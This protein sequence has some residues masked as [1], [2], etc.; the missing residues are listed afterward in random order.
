MIYLLCVRCV[1]FVLP[2]CRL[3]AGR[4]GR[5][6]CDLKKWTQRTLRPDPDSHRDTKF[7]KDLYRSI[8]EN[9]S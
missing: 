3:P 5:Q 6:V 4:Q 9:S 2:A 7:T 8:I 1:F